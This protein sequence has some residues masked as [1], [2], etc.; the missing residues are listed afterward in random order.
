MGRRGILLGMALGWIAIG[1]SQAHHSTSTY[2][3][4]KTLQLTGVV[5]TFEWTNPHNWLELLVT[6]SSGQDV[7]WVIEAGTPN[8]N[9]RM[10]WTG[11]DLN[12]GDKVE[13]SIHPKRDG[14]PNGTLVT[15]RLPD[16]KSLNGPASLF[17]DKP[18]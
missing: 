6:D 11:S 15:V 7:K 9:R 14:T 8:V 17:G 18:Q 10:G 16:G 3:S 5:K 4:S 13:V 1:T 2:D 12:E